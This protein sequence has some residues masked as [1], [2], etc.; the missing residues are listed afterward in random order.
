MKKFAKYLL[1][2]YFPLPLPIVIL[3]FS[4][5]IKTA[6]SRP[7]IS[8]AYAPEVN[9]YGWVTKL[10]KVKGFILGSSTLQLGL[11]AGALAQNDSIWIN[12]SMQARDPVE[13]FLLL[14]KYYPMKRPNIVLVGLDPWIYSKLY[15]K[16]RNNVMY[17]DLNGAK[18]VRFLR[19]DPFVLVKRAEALLSPLP[20]PA[21]TDSG[22]LYNYTVP[23]DYGSRAIHQTP[24]NFNQVGDDFD[25]KDFGWSEIQFSYLEKIDSFCKQNKVKVIYL[26]PPKRRDFVLKSVS[27][28]ANEQKIWWRKICQILR[29]ESIIG[30][31]DEFRNYDQKQVFMDAYHLN[32]Y[33]QKLYTQMVKDSMCCGKAINCDYNFLGPSIRS[34]NQ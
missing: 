29:G 26:V 6:P 22:H 14:E 9:G 31:Y 19:K 15:Y 3:S 33:G 5:F 7:L 16:Y 23:P 17:L 8:L 25:I 13:S 2:S 28:L 1:L 27:T 32:A 10:Q 4:I 30:T 21:K 20:Y 12:F 24:V 18:L 11:S 34:D